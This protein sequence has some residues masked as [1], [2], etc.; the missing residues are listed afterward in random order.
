[1]Y[2]ISL[3]YTLTLHRRVIIST[4]WLVLSSRSAG[5]GIQVVRA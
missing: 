1:M 3:R 2:V 4:N 5:T